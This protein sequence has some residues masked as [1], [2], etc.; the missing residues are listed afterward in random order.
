[1]IRLTDIYPAILALGAVAM[2]FCTSA[3]ASSRI[4][5]KADAANNLTTQELYRIYRGRS[6]M[7]SD[8]GAYFRISKREFTAW[9]GHGSKSTIAK[10][11]WY[12]P[13]KGK[14]CFRATWT[15]VEW[16]VR[17][18]TCFAHKADSRNIFQ[19]KLPDGKWYVFKHKPVR[20]YDEFRKLKRGNHISR[21]YARNSRYIN[22]R[23]S[24]KN[25]RAEISFSGFLVC[26]F[27]R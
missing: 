2:L 11:I 1:M 27:R 25:C 24:S 13:G 4:A 10:G 23:R 5:G 18:R 7:W 8:G 17:K 19:R 3:T 22:T 16:S 14:A 20:R 9:V 15:A 26:L 12:L 21:N 6:W